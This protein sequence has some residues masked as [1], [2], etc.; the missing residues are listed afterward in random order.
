MLR[1]Q[2]NHA[3]PMHALIIRPPNSH[4]LKTV[5]DL[6]KRYAEGREMAAQVG[7]NTIGAYA[8]LGRYDLMF[9]YEAP[10][11]KTA[12]GMPLSFAPAGGGQTETGTAIPMEEFVQLTG[13]TSK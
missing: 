11:E 4:I 10:D 1:N 8:L 6:G 5:G 12:A 13:G 3:F 2:L 7:I 9:I